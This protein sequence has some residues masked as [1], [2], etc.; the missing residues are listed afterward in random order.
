MNALQLMQH[1]F[2]LKKHNARVALCNYQLTGLHFYLCHAI[3]D[4]RLAL[5][6]L[7]QLKENNHETHH[8]YR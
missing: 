5:S 7:K 2:N 4:T 3:A 6:F 8:R 1:N